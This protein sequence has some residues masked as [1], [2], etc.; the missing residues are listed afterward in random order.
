MNNGL[1]SAKPEKGDSEDSAIVFCGLKDL[2]KKLAGKN[3]VVLTD[4]LI[5]DTLWLNVAKNSE[6]AQDMRSAGDYKSESHNAVQGEF[7]EA[8]LV[9]VP[10]G[11]RPNRWRRLR[12]S[13][14]P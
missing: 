13:M 4:G 2:A 14:Q 5:N 11:E 1:E 3:V 7:P 9:I 6:L 10:Q 8:S 12:R